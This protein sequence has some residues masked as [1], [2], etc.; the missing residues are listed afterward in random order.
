MLA[1]IYLLY[2]TIMLGSMLLILECLGDFRTCL[3]LKKTEISS[4]CSQTMILDTDAIMTYKPWAGLSFYGVSM[5]VH[6]KDD[7]IASTTLEPVGLPS[8]H[9]S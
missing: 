1:V 5:D 9:H 7:L 6:Y 2:A 4:M 3:D 8:A